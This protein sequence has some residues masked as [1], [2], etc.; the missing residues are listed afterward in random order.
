ML[1]KSILIIALIFIFIAFNVCKK[2]YE[3]SVIQS[4]KDILFNIV[5]IDTE[6]AQLMLYD[7]SVAKKV[8]SRDDDPT[9][10]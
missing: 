3:F 8:S 4:G 2:L 6:S 7:I 1:R 9:F 10:T 5:D